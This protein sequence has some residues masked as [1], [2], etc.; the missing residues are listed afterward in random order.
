LWIDFRRGIAWALLTNR[1][2]PTRHRETGIADLRRQ[3]G[4]LIAGI[5]A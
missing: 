3:V 1:V 4:D 2:H 5:A